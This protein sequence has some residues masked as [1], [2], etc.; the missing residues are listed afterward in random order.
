MIVWLIAVI[1]HTPIDDSNNKQNENE[2][3]TAKSPVE[4]K[5][6]GTLV[7]MQLKCIKS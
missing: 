6:K 1:S 7:W 3:A 5:N 4:N 2:E